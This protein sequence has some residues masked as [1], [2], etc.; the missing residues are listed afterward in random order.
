M[1]ALSLPG[2]ANILPGPGVDILPTVGM[3]RADLTSGAAMPAAASAKLS[4][5]RGFAKVLRAQTAGAASVAVPVE[6]PAAMRLPSAPAF[7]SASIAQPATGKESPAGG[8]ILPATSQPVQADRPG[9]R[10]RSDG[11][12]PVS[13]SA[14]PLDLAGPVAGALGAGGL[15]AP[16]LSPT[17]APALPSATTAPQP[18]AA[19]PEQTSL[20]GAGAAMPVA[21]VPEAVATAGPE[22]A[23]ACGAPDAI[24]AAAPAPAFAV[25]AT[26]GGAAAVMPLSFGRSLSLAVDPAPLA[27]AAAASPSHAPI[28]VA[29]DPAVR[30][31]ARAGTDPTTAIAATL[32]G[33]MPI[34]DAATLLPPAPVAA[35]S[36]A[37]HQVANAAETN[38]A[39]APIAMAAAPNATHPLHVAAPRY[40]VRQATVGSPA[41]PPLAG[42]VS[43]GSPAPATSIAASPAPADYAA[44]VDRLLE[45]RAVAQSNAP[46][47]SVQTAIDHAEFGQITLRFEPSRDGLSVN[48]TSRDPGFA[49]AAQAA[50]LKDAAQPQ[51]RDTASASPGAA[52]TSSPASTTSGNGDAP[53]HHADGH[54]PHAGFAPDSGSRSFNQQ[55]PRHAAPDPSAP[56]APAAQPARAAAASTAAPTTNPG[57]D[58]FA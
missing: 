18:G 33:A 47:A 37:S 51:A 10:A 25:L 1:T 50:M 52:A 55:S 44:L 8:K 39:P 57:S 43:T 27:P 29:A 54:L 14:A 7:S 12:A 11:P 16:T 56:Y 58:I 34:P 30:A 4:D 3:A 13:K 15:I 23:S 46:G 42:V 31:F 48:M 32:P 17:L 22:D 40:S 36:V 53:R 49:P 21:L 19:A 20:V 9:K 38:P 6:A 24:A 26:L 41:P 2:A 5:F 35:S 45:A 28:T